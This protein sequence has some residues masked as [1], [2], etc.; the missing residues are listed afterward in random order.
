ME[1]HGLGGQLELRP[2]HCHHLGVYLEQL[3]VFH[4]PAGL[5]DQRKDLQTESTSWVRSTRGKS[6][7]SP[8]FWNKAQLRSLFPQNW[9]SCWGE[10]VPPSSSWTARWSYILWWSRR[11]T[12]V[13]LLPP[14]RTS[15]GSS[16]KWLL[17]IIITFLSSLNAF[18]AVSSSRDPG[19]VLFSMF[20]RKKTNTFLNLSRRLTRESAILWRH[21]LGKLSHCSKLFRWSQNH[22]IYSFLVNGFQVETWSRYFNHAP[23]PAFLALWSSERGELERRSGEVFGRRGPPPNEPEWRGTEHSHAWHDKM[24]KFKWF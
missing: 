18:V 1:V 5:R 10:S 19:V 3:A 8:R 7:G 12:P 17:K 13:W 4:Q 24:S 16:S 15:S 20:C 6:G 14:R 22:H 21:A 11:C 23:P 9:S 2:R